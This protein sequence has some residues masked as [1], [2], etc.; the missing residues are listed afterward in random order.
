MK[1]SRKRTVDATLTSASVYQGMNALEPGAGVLNK[2]AASNDGSNPTLTKSVGPRA[3]N[4]SAPDPSEP[5]LKPHLASDI[6]GVHDRGRQRDRRR[7]DLSDQIGPRPKLR[8]ASS[9]A[10]SMD[11]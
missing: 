10:R 2:S 8:T 1:C 6:C 3:T 9:A 7:S 5:S 11:G 4:K